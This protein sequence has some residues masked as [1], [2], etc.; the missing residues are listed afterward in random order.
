MNNQSVPRT[1]KFFAPVLIPLLLV[2]FIACAS[3]SANKP[4]AG[5]ATGELVISRSFSLAGLPVELMIDD[6]RVTTIPFNRKYHV[7]LAVGWHTLGVRQI[8]RTDRS[9][10][11][12]VRL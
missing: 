12:D 8:P 4:A 2:I 9:R 5:A 10:S 3:D 6:K 7:S 1:W 11:S